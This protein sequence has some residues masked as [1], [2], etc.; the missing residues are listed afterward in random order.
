MPEPLSPSLKFHL[1]FQARDFLHALA[2]DELV[3]AAVP[4][5]DV[6]A[7]FRHSG[8]A[9]IR[10]FDVDVPFMQLQRHGWGILPAVSAGRAGG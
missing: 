6:R 8:T 3:P 9:C 4:H 5:A 10:S 2:L 7:S 1:G